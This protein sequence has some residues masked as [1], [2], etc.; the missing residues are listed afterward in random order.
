MWNPATKLDVYKSAD[1]N[2][3]TIRDNDG[4]CTLNPESGGS[5][6]CTSDI[7]LKTNISNL[8]NG[9]SIIDQLR[10]VTYNM[11]NNSD[12]SLKT[13]FIV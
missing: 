6:S 10:P 4:T 7:R 1:E 12:F 13:G 11:I 3:V 8:K 9:L 2:I 5:W